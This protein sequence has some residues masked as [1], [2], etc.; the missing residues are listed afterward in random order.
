MVE[1]VA[2]ANRAHTTLEEYLLRPQPPQ[3]PGSAYFSQEAIEAR[4]RQ[5]VA[6]LGDDPKAAVAAASARCTAL[7]G[8]TPGQA[9]IG[10]PA[11]TM[12]L[13]AY[14]PSRV[15]ELSIHGLD[16][17]RA[18]RAEVAAPPDALVESLRFLTGRAAQRGDGELILLAMSGRSQ[19]PAGFSVY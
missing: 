6:A 12:S 4:G 5:A 19:L 9:T 17:A 2:H 10:S 15:A 7:V 11:G 18:C 14:L 8:A 1:L 16:I 13:A 3:A